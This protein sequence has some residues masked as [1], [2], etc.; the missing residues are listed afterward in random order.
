M[1]THNKKPWIGAISENGSVTWTD[2]RN[3]IFS[4]FL[5]GRPESGRKC[6]RLENWN[7]EYGSNYANFPK[8]KQ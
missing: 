3:W 1:K 2:N 7:G 5:F 6:I 8:G 4:N